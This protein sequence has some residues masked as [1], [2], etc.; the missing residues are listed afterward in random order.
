MRCRDNSYS[1]KSLKER[2]ESIMK[3]KNK[4]LIGIAAAVVVV[5][6]ISI[7]FATSATANKSKNPD[8]TIIQEEQSQQEQIAEKPL[9]TAEKQVS[10]I[11]EGYQEKLLFVSRGETTV[12]VTYDSQTWEPY[13]TDLDKQDWIWYTYEEKKAEFENAS[14]AVANTMSQEGLD[15]GR[16]RHD[17]ILSDIENGIKFSRTKSIYIMDPGPQGEAS[18]LNGII[19][20]YCFGYSFTDKAGNEIDLGLFETRDQLFAVLREYYDHEVAAGRL[21]QTEADDLFTNVAHSERL[22]AE[23]PLAEKLANQDKY[24][25]L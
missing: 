23:V 14:K 16:A 20:W 17:R 25:W 15:I 11:G 7:V 6:V 18:A 12:K 21:S 2:V 3:T 4:T 22:P 10:A 8:T 19:Y 13:D 24:G 1:K 5:A 9:Q